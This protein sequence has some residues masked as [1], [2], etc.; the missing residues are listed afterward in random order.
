MATMINWYVFE[1]HHHFRIM[2][3]L[4]KLAM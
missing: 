4:N 2:I 3:Q 1:I